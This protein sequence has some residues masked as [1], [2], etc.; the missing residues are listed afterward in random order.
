MQLILGDIASG[1]GL[2]KDDVP[3]LYRQLSNFC[4]PPP[5]PILL[6]HFVLDKSSQVKTEKAHEFHFL[7][8]KE[9]GK[10]S[11]ASSPSSCGMVG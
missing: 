3:P 2:Q 4:G 11:C 1:G 7:S 6:S 10:D 5:Y 8:G 9:I